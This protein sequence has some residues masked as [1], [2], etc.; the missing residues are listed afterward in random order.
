MSVSAPALL[1]V[2]EDVGMVEVC[3]SL[4]VIE[5]EETEREFIVTLATKD[6]SGKLLYV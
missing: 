3:V 5:M 2:L 4:S 1:N 6:S